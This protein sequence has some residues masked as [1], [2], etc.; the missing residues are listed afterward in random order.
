MTSKKFL[1]T[2][3]LESAAPALAGCLE[4]TNNFLRA[5]LEGKIP[6][7]AYAEILQ[8]CTYTEQV[9]SE[10]PKDDGVEAY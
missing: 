6:Q 1:S 4:T 7:E 5:V 2:P 8:H 9:L 3:A 10:F